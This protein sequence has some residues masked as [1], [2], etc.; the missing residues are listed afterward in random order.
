M[1]ENIEVTP[2]PGYYNYNQ[3]SSKIN[4]KKRTKSVGGAVHKMKEKYKT[5]YQ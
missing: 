3:N 5:E 1:T 2:G 4:V